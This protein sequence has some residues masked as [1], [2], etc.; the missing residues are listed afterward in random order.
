MSEE[1]LHPIKIEDWDFR[2][3]PE[4]EK[5][6]CCIWE[7]AR[8][9]STI[10]MSADLHWVNVR[11]IINKDLYSKDHEAKKKDDALAEV[12]EKRARHADFDY[13]RFLS[14]YYET[15]FAYVEGF[16][17]IMHHAGDG[18]IS[19]QRIPKDIRTHI[20]QSISQSHVFH[21]LVEAQVLHLESLWL[22][23][24]DPLASA[25]AKSEEDGGDSAMFA[26]LDRVCP[27]P[28]DDE[29]SNPSKGQVTIAFDIDFAR[30]SD[31][32]IVDSLRAWIAENRPVD[33]RTPKRVLFDTPIRGKKHSEFTVALDR[34]GLMR[35][36]HWYPPKKLQ[37]EWPSAWMLFGHK[38]ESFRRE[39]REAEKYFRELFPFLPPDELPISRER[40]GT[41][42]PRMMKICDE[43]ER[44]MSGETKDEG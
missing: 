42:M 43:V 29:N 21:P 28:I 25:R 41:W 24:R 15:D 17:D 13:D 10:A 34:L 36:L 44:E 33:C 30:F 26:E 37:D 39:I 7:Y 3:V 32:Q 8:E 18:A 23:H 9:S 20:S 40:F 22:A 31:S 11:H 35:L 16:E 27:L 5:A 2:E 12:I 19:W 1:D 38:E 14:D 4:E 6:A